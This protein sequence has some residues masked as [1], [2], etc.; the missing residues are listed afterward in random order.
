MFYF[1]HNFAITLRDILG[2]ISSTDNSVCLEKENGLE[3][4]SFTSIGLLWSCFAVSRGHTRTSFFFGD[5]V[6][7]LGARGRRSQKLIWGS[8]WA[9]WFDGHISCFWQQ[10][11]QGS[12]LRLRLALESRWKSFGE[13]SMG[14]TIKKRALLH[15]RHDIMMRTLKT[16]LV[17]KDIKVASVVFVHISGKTLVKMGEICEKWGKISWKMWRAVE[18]RNFISLSVIVSGSRR[19]VFLWRVWK[20]AWNDEVMWASSS[21]SWALTL[22]KKELTMEKPIGLWKVVLAKMKLYYILLYTICIYTLKA[23]QPEIGWSWAF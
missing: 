6:A 8:W 9:R 12:S 18:F 23:D 2:S 13:N 11:S 22:G 3:N 20:I 5:R 17:T 21:Q 4:R 7:P 16:G 1:W 15:I 10:V 14:K 19:L